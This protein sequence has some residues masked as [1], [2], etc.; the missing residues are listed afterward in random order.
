MSAYPCNNCIREERCTNVCGE[1]A[2]WF[3]PAWNELTA[4]LREKY[5]LVLNEVKSE[6]TT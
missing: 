1:F 2:A 5:G 3:V 4:K 6:E